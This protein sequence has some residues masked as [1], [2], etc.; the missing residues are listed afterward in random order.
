MFN[1]SPKRT[2]THDVAVLVPIDAGHEEQTLKTTFNFLDTEELKDFDLRTLEGST[3]FLN[4]IVASFHDLV[5]GDGGPVPY[6]EEL[7]NRLIRRQYVRSALLSHYGEA[8]TK[9][10]EGN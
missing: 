8:V 9:A 10:K 5:D 6:S 1:V 2:F 7:R 4:A 3:A